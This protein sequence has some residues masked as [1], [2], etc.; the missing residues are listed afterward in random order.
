MT[1]VRMLVCTTVCAAAL[2]ALPPSPAGAGTTG[3][4]LEKINARRVAHDQPP[5]RLS[6]SLRRTARRHARF[7]MRSGLF[8]HSTRISVSRPF[9]QVG[10]IL[11]RHRGTRPRPGYA[12]GLWMRSR[13]HRTE[14][15]DPVYRWVGIARVAGRWRGRRATIWVVHSGRL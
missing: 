3:A 6:R 2:L 10:E 14:L 1:Y 4:M 12:V 8:A 5:L 13:T 11:E 9:R 7:L 15:L